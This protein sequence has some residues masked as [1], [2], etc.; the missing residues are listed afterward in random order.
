MIPVF[1]TMWAGL[2]P[3]YYQQAIQDLAR[4]GYVFALM[5]DTPSMPQLY[6]LFSG[7][8]HWIDMGRLMH[9]PAEGKDWMQHPEKFE[10]YIRTW[11]RTTA[12]GRKDFVPIGDGYSM[13]DDVEIKD[14]G[15][16][17]WRVLPRNGG[18]RSRRE[19]R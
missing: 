6:G 10:H 14:W 8:Y 9:P 17:Q 3:N 16:G 19:K 11:M 4:Q 13:F 12:A 15:A 18:S 5:A 1:G 2:L 7:G